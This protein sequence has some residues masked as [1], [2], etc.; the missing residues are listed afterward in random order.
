[1]VGL[2][3]I[4]ADL[5]VEKVSLNKKRRNLWGPKVVLERV[6]LTSLKVVLEKVSLA[7]P[8]VVLGG[9]GKWYNSRQPKVEC[10]SQLGPPEEGT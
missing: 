2:A 8:K 5:V 10:K 6:V 1:M 9:H 4:E 3:R 7:S